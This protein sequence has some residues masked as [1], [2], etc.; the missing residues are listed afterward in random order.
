MMRIFKLCLLLGCAFSL[1]ACFGSGS[2]GG[3]GG[4]AHIATNL[5]QGAQQAPVQADT[6][7]FNN[8]SGW[9][10]GPF[11]PGTNSL[12]LIDPHSNVFAEFN[13]D[14]FHSTTDTISDH[15]W[16]T[17]EIDMDVQ[18][19][20]DNLDIFTYPAGQQTETVFTDTDGHGESTKFTGTVTYG[21]QTLLINDRELNVELEHATFGAWYYT[22]TWNGI[23]TDLNG[24]NPRTEANYTEQVYHPF[25]GADTGAT[26]AAP[27][28]NDT[29]TTGA[30]HAQF[31]QYRDSGSYISEFRSGTAELSIGGSANSGSLAL[32]FP[33]AYHIGFNDISID[34][35]GTISVN[36]GNIPTVTPNNNTT[37]ISL[38]SADINK[39][40]VK[41]EGQFYG[42][43]TA[44]E[45][46]GTFGIGFE[47]D[48]EIL[49]SFGVKK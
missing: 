6:N 43:S 22:S 47:G 21:K 38:N 20:S 42:S 49:G 30:A 15:K 25:H 33:N 8:S 27:A 1:T 24:A 17:A 13:D 16:L 23:T 36:Y 44:S 5:V 40:D 46:A 26:Q 34:A 11:K 9:H 41:L 3:S 29:F 10:I 28:A 19:I 48:K 18:N 2:G 14:D 31:A 45:A 7:A 35:N 4:G 32:T 37:G 12:T 39:G